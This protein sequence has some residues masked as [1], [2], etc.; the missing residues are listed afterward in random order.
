MQRRNCAYVK[1]KIVCI[2]VIHFKSLCLRAQLPGAD[3]QH[4]ALLAIQ[5]ISYKWHS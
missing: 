5:F 1:K 2:Q 4:A 3:P